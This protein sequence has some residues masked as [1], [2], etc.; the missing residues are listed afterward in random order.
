MTGKWRAPLPAA[1]GVTAAAVL[2]AAGST[3]WS[4]G[5]PDAN[6]EALSTITSDSWSAEQ[7]VPGGA[8]RDEARRVFESFAGTPAEQNALSVVQAHAAN[9]DMDSCMESAG[10]P[11]WD[12]SLSRTYAAPPDP[13]NSQFWLAEPLRRWRSADLLAMRPFLEAEK[14]MNADNTSVGMDEAVTSCLKAVTPRSEATLDQ[15]APR[16]IE[17]LT[18]EWYGMVSALGDEFALPSAS[19]YLD[20]MDASDV[21]ALDDIDAPA[22]EIGP[23]MS[24][25][26]PSD[27]DIPRSLDDSARWNSGGWQHLLRG[28]DELIEADWSCRMD[29][30]V[31]AINDVL[32]HIKEFAEQHT[33]EIATA[34]RAWKQVVADAEELGYRG[35]EGPLGQ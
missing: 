29:V 17:R 26:G 34:R 3:I 14:V 19:T 2:G 16:L 20:C 13:L 22:T 33:D 6:Q 12:W 23:A 35:Q 4:S 5:A 25:L 1:V 27:S 11:E 32:P 24:R 7:D 28:E 18:L 30:Y 31:A 8:V 10:Y 15:A 9:A 21:S